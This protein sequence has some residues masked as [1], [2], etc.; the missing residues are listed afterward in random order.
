MSIRIHPAKVVG[1]VY[2]CEKCGASVEKVKDHEPGLIIHECPKCKKRC[3][4]D[5]E[6][7]FVNFKI[8]TKPRIVRMWLKIFKRKGE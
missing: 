5:R 7:P 4:L 6:Y 3:M 2:H 1:Y 8:Q